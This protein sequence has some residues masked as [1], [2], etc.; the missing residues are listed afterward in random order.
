MATIILTGAN[1][2][3]GYYMAQQLLEDGHQVAVLDLLTD[4]LAGLHALYVKRLMPFVCDVTDAAAVTKAVQGAAQE[5]GAIDYAI[6]NACVCTFLGFLESDEEMFRRVHEV[7]FYGALHL[8]KAVLPVMLQQKRG[9]VFFVSSGVGVMGFTN[10]SPY[11]SSKGALESLAKCLQLEY[12]AQ[13]ITF[14][15]MHPPLTRTASSSPLPV[16]EEMKE[17]PEKVGRGLAKRLN[18]NKFI[19]CHSAFQALQT[20]MAYRFPL[21]LG[22]L[23]SK[24]TANFEQAGVKNDV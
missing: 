3:I 2:G 8:A 7:N 15:L 12:R 5:F 10:I 9:R 22:G 1:Q 6:H 14:H 23:M 21:A 19:I 4:G 20:K 13:G 24:M 16:P 17:D 18:Q 11:A